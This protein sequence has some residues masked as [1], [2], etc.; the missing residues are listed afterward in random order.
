MAVRMALMVTAVAAL[1]AYVT[2][3][4]AAAQGVLMGGI[5]GILGFWFMAVRLEKRVQK[6]EQAMKSAVLTW[7]ALRLALYGVVLAKAYTLDPASLRGLVGAVVGLMAIRFAQVFLGFT[8]LDL[9]L[10]GGLNQ[11]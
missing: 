4:K 8:G 7:S 6:P 5:A 3:E 2:F 10:D 9:R 1:I 11:K